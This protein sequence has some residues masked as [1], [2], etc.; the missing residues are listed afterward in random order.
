MSYMQ[1]AVREEASFRGQFE[2]EKEWICTC[3]DTW[4]RNPFFTGTPSGKHPE[5][6]PEDWT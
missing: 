4:E 6:Y 1:D 3:M 5:D 2:T